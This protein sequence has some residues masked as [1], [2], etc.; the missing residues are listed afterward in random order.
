MAQLFFTFSLSLSLL[1]CLPLFTIFHLSFPFA[2]VLIKRSTFFAIFLECYQQSSI[3]FYTSHMQKP[4]CSTSIFS[5]SLSHPFRTTHH[6]LTAAQVVRAAGSV[7]SPQW[8]PA[9]SGWLSECQVAGVLRRCRSFNLRH[10][11]QDVILSVSLLQV[12]GGHCCCCCCPH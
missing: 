9:A 2:F 3:P 11:P 7:A 4:I 6:Y 1:L 5:L 8:Q 10:Q 12:A